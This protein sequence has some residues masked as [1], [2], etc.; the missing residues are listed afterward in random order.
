MFHRRGRSSC[1]SVLLDPDGEHLVFGL[2]L[3]IRIF[4]REM[5]IAYTCVYLR[6]S[7]A[8]CRYFLLLRFETLLIYVSQRHGAS[9]SLAYRVEHLY[10]EI[11]AGRRTC[12]SHKP[13]VGID[14]R[15]RLGSG[16]RFGYA[17]LALTLCANFV[18]FYPTFTDNFRSSSAKR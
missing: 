14:I 8:A 9:A 17:D 15:T 10:S 7:D 18:D 1:S 16:S 3:L 4:D 6:Y 11:D 5:I 13:F 12:D 2:I